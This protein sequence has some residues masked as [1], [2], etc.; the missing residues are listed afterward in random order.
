MIEIV[1]VSPKFKVLN[2]ELPGAGYLE[3]V[4]AYLFRGEKAAI[5][6]IGPKALVPEVLSAVS[7]LGVSL[8]E[9]E[10]IILTHIHLD[11]AGGVGTLIKEMP[12]AKVVAHSR[13]RPHLID[14]AMLWEAS[15]KTLGDVPLQYGQLEP[16]PADK[17]IDA[18]DGMKLDLGAGLT[19]E[20]L[21]TPGHASHHLSLFDRANSVLIAGEAAGINM[22]GL[23]RPNTPPPFHLEDGLASLDRLIALQPQK[24]CYAH[25]G[26]YDNGVERLKASHE[27]LIAWYELVKS[28]TEAGKSPQEILSLLREKDKNLVYLERVSGYKLDREK[29][30]LIN[31]ILGLA[32][33]AKKT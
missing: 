22:D 24:L 33:S 26:C 8:P 1:N 20:V 25:F 18:A 10:Y 15:L 32:G 13:A 4:A 28:A 9:F 6:D 21:L 23:L 12:N 31:T 27:Q 19:L 5:I 7:Q 3:F 11:H 16:V 2:L 17:I 29:G 14:P 30:Q